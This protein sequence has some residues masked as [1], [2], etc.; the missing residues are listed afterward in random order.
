MEFGANMKKE[1]WPFGGTA[2]L[3][4]RVAFDANKR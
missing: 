3:Y 2:I 4:D 1:T